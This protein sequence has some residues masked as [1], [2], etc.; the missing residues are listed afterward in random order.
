M[1]LFLPTLLLVIFSH[2][3]SFPYFFMWYYVMQLFLPTLLLVI[4]SHSFSFPHFFMWYYLMQLSFKRFPSHI[5]FLWYYFMQLFLLTLLLVISHTVLP[6]KTFSCDIISCSSSFSDF[7]W[8]MLSHAALPSHTFSCDIIS[9]SSSFPQFSMWYY[10]MQLSFKW[11][12][13]TL[14]LVIFLL[15]H[16]K[17]FQTTFCAHPTSFPR[18]LPQCLSTAISDLTSWHDRMPPSIGH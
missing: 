11:F 13:P 17:P 4:L 9:C 12:L 7:M 5:V 1:Q 18:L 14:L 10:L 16:G 15:T 8:H 2:H 6:S 3:S